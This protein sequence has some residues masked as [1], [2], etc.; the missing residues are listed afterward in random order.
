MLTL[1]SDPFNLVQGDP[2]V[3]LI[4]ARN[5]IGWADAFSPANNGNDVPVQSVPPAPASAPTSSQQTTSS[6]IIAMPEID[7][8]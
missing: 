3:A 1:T 2:I 6:L 4:K 7:V 5:S 8:S